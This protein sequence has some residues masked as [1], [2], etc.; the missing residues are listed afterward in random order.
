MAHGRSFSASGQVVLNAQE[1]F[2]ADAVEARGHGAGRLAELGGDLLDGAAEV[3]AAA[4]YLAFALGQPGHAHAEHA[5]A[6]VHFG[7]ERAGLGRHEPEQFGIEH[8]PVALGV[9]EP[10]ED[11]EVGDAAGPGA[12]LRAFDELVRLAP[13]D[14]V[15]FPEARRPRRR[16]SAA[17]SG[18]RA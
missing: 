8:K 2:V 11:L 6:V 17:A 5:A 16:G 13:E 4:E 18:C 15:R 9:A 14:Q 12:E 1:Q 10:G 3:V 7:A